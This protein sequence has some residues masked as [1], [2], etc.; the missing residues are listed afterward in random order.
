MIEKLGMSG[1]AFITARIENYPGFVEGI[2]VP[3]L[4]HNMEE[5]AKSFGLKTF[6]GEVIRVRVSDEGT[7][8][9]ICVN[10]EP[11]PYRCLPII[12]AAGHEQGKLG[13]PGEIEFTGQGVSYCATCDGAFFRDLTVAVVGGGDMAVEEAFF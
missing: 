2:S 5:Q 7:I 9:K 6:F 12:V 3:E 11:E 13:V 1:Q 4:V 10:D 8:K